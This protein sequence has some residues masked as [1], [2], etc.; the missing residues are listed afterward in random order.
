MTGQVGIVPKR[1]GAKAQ[2]WVPDD[3]VDI[4]PAGCM[5]KCI[6]H[7]TMQHAELSVA[8]GHVDRESHKKRPY[9]LLLKCQ[10]ESRKR[11]HQSGGGREGKG[12]WK[13]DRH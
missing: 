6:G 3:L 7:Q 4:A 5:L 13:K 2:H 1:C 9:L 12:S 10:R 11:M 8:A